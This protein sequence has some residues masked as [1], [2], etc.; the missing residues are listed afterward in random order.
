MQEAICLIG[1]QASG[2]TTTANKLREQGYYVISSDDIRREHTGIASLD[3]FVIFYKRIVEALQY[4]KS[5]VCEATNLTFK[6]RQFFFEAIRKFGQPVKKIALIVNTPIDECKKRLEE[7]NNSSY[8]MKFGP[9]VIDRYVRSF[10]MPTYTEGFDEIRTVGETIKEDYYKDKFVESMNFKHN[11]MWHINETVN[12][13]VQK[14]IN[15]YKADP[16]G[17]EYFPDENEFILCAKY[18]DYGKYLTA[19][20]NPKYPEYLTYRDHGQIGAWELAAYANSESIKNTFYVPLIIASY[21][22]SVSDMKQKTLDRRF[23]KD[24]QKK[25]LYFERLDKE[26][27]SLTRKEYEEAQKLGN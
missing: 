26:A 21:H 27:S 4:G 8:D 6:A 24:E 18:H 9:E 5:I 11:D 22:M 16:S 1:I 2:K 14:I 3:V 12:E 15:L 7:R 17:K 13:H 19:M 10:Q 25:L 23:S 20:P